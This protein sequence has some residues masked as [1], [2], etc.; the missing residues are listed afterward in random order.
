MI[1]RVRIAHESRWCAP[2]RALLERTISPSKEASAHEIIGIDTES[3]RVSGFCGGKEWRVV[4]GNVCI[5][6]TE[7]GETLDA[8]AANHDVWACEHILEMD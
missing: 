5:T 8:L 6:N 4:A 1:A 3:M 2:L 7:T